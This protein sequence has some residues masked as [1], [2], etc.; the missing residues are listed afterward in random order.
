[1]NKTIFQ[2]L[3]INGLKMLSVFKKINNKIIFFAVLLALTGKSLIFP[4]LSL[5][6][7]VSTF[8]SSDHICWSRPYP[9]L[10]V[11]NL[12][13]YI[14]MRSLSYK[15][16]FSFSCYF[17]NWSIYCNTHSLVGVFSYIYIFCGFPYSFSKLSLRVYSIHCTLNSS[18]LYLFLS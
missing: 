18:S 3:I 2:Y 13:L 11:S 10:R 6:I 7:R 9:I 5:L 1:M 15:S 16:R 14:L 17:L 12:P 4:I 8:R